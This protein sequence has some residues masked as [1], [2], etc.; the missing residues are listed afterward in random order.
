MPRKKKMEDKEQLIYCS[1][2][3]CP[4]S[5][6]LRHKSNTPWGVMVHMYKFIPDKDWN[7]KYILEE[8]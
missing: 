8:Y 5:N 7:C 4:N 6:C 3:K 2:M 1:Q